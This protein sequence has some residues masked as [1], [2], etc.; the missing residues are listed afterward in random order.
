MQTEGL[1]VLDLALIEYISLNK[2]VFWLYEPLFPEKNIPFSVP[3]VPWKDLWL[4]IFIQNRKLDLVFDLLD[5]GVDPNS[6]GPIPLVEAIKQENLALVEKLLQCKANPNFEP[7]I[8]EA[9]KL[10]SR[11][12]FDLL[13]AY[14]ADPG[15]HI[16]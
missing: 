4:T 15:K 2:D 11:E 12:I 5:A 6:Y 16:L 10:E 7:V 13:V 8:R 3:K 9:V 1:T 14:G